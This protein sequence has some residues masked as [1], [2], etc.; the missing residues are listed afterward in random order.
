MDQKQLQEFRE[1]FAILVE[2]GFVAV[3]QLDETSATQLFRAAEM[4]HPESPAPQVGLGYIH[5]NKLETAKAIAIFEKIVEKEPDHHLAQA[6]LGICYALKKNTRKK[7]EE[8]LRQAMEASNDPT[9]KNLG[10]V[11]LKWIDKD[12]KSAKAPFFKESEKDVKVKD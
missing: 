8:M 12:L 2:A 1:D 11:S 4:L 3:K 6:F 5:M 9:I 7:G 10:E